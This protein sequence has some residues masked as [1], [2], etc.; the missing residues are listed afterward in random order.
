MGLDNWQQRTELLIGNNK[1]EKLRKANIL[2]A[3]LGGVG[4]FAAEIL[5]RSGVGNMTIVDADTFHLSNRNRQIGALKSTE[6][7]TKTSVM[8]ERLLDINPDLN[9]TL[10]HEFITEEKIKQ[11][12]ALPW[13]YIVDA[14]DSLNPKIFLIY[15]SLQAKVKLIS[16]MGAGG[17][18][19]PSHIQ[20]TDFSKTYNDKLARMLRKRLHKMDVFSGFDVV[21]SPEKI[22]KKAVVLTDS[23][24]NKKTTVGTISYMPLMFGAFMASHVIRNIAEIRT[25]EI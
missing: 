9:L 16:S 10:V 23:E 1:L 5:C 4:G 24:R 14:I 3:G 22:D 6:G 11:L 17:K 21:F 18:T 2:V 20:I 25:N 8:Q 12:T 13:D 7:R 15:Y 19:D